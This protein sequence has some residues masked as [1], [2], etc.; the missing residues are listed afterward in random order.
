MYLFLFIPCLFRN[1]KDTEEWHESIS[2]LALRPLEDFSI[3]DIWIV[4]RDAE[5][6]R[7]GQ[8]KILGLN[9]IVSYSST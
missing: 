1:E 3:A 6:H 7:A 2:E 5:I 9:T 4:T 8:I